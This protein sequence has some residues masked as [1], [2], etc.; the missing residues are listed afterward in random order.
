MME[1]LVASVIVAMIIAIFGLGLL[2]MPP[3]RKRP[4][5]AI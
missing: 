1:V 2:A 3:R 4:H 5:D